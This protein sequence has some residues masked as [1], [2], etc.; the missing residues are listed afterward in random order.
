MEMELTNQLMI[1]LLSYDLCFVQGNLFCKC[2]TD[3][4]YK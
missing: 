2:I 3:Y 1:L 4:S